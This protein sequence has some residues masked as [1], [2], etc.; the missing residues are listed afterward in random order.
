L[1][2]N[3]CITSIQK[4]TNNI[5]GVNGI[6]AICVSL[7]LIF[8][9][10]LVLIIRK[11]RKFDPK[12][13]KFSQTII[14]DFSERNLVAKREESSAKSEFIIEDLPYHVKRI[15]VHGVNSLHRP[16]HIKAETQFNESIDTLRLEQ[17]ITQFNICAAYSSF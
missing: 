10:G 12:F 15:Y 4:L 8:I 13:K 14:E 9:S 3:E 6:F 2:N 1:I 5:G 16:W 17:F 7:L 11:K